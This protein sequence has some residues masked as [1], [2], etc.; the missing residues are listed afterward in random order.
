V[1][2]SVGRIVHFMSPYGGLC[3]AAIITLVHNRG[4]IGREEAQV[5]LVVFTTGGI[6]FYENI[7]FSEDEKTWPTWHWPERIEE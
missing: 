3:E 7:P 1:K 6:S 4:E 5:S 2:P